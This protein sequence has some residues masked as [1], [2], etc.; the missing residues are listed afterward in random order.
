VA[1]IDGGKAL[2]SMSWLKDR[3]QSSSLIAGMWRTQSFKAN[4]VLFVLMESLARPTR[5]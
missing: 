1:V 2:N 3:I 5:E 4:N